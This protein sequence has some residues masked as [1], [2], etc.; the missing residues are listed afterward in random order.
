MGQPEFT[1]SKIPLLNRS[2]ADKFT[3]QVGTSQVEFSALSIGNPHAVVQVQDVGQ[4]PLDYWGK[5]LNS[6]PGKICYNRKC[7]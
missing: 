5:L 3:L 6:T 2:Q 1:I 7:T 4:A